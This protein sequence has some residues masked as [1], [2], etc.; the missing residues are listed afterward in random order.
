MNTIAANRLFVNAPSLSIDQSKSN[1]GAIKINPNQAAAKLWQI[2][3]KV[4]RTAL[5]RVGIIFL[6]ITAFPAPVYALQEDATQGCVITGG[7]PSLGCLSQIVVSVIN[8][9]FMFVTAVTII[10][11]LFGAF[12]FVIS[13][14]DPKAL[15]SARGTMTYAIVGMIII[16]FSFAIVQIITQMLG[17]PSFLTNFTIYQP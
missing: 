7:A 4:L 6:I 16:F 15:Q 3:E 1:A 12:K 9:L 14:G 8:Y 11:L 2:P 17:L 13:R 10:F 5:V